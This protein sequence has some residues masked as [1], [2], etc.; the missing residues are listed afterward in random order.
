MICQHIAS[1][2]QSSGSSS[3]PSMQSTRLVGQSIFSQ[4]PAD[5]KVLPTASL[6]GATALKDP[7]PDF[8]QHSYPTSPAHPME[9]EGEVSDQDTDMLEQ[10]LDQQLSDEQN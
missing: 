7:D 6:A 1:Y 2:N 4:S 8:Y 5:K 9:E 10:E 3:M